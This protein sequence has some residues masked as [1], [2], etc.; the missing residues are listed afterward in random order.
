MQGS[1]EMKA[2]SEGAFDW[3]ENIYNPDQFGVGVG[4]SLFEANQMVF[5]CEGRFG[6]DILRPAGIVEID[7]TA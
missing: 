6:L 4:G 1:I 2:N 7:L 3:S 5:R